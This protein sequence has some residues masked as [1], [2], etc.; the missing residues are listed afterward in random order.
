MKLYL[1]QKT[2][3]GMGLV[4]VSTIE[5]GKRPSSDD[6]L[7]FELMVMYLKSFVLDISTQQLLSC[8]VNIRKSS[9]PDPSLW[10]KTL[11]ERGKRGC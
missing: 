1:D 9:S 6:V 4:L 10:Q 5:S 8:S 11:L 2:Q 7:E 3:K